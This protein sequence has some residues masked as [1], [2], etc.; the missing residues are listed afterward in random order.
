MRDLLIGVGYFLTT[1]WVTFYGVCL[2]LNPRRFSTFLSRP[3]FARR[4]MEQVQDWTERDGRYWRKQGVV[5]AV[6]GMFMFLMPLVIAVMH[7]DD[8]VSPTTTPEPHHSIASG[9]PSY[10]VWSLFLCLGISLVA[11]PLS[12]LRY[13]RPDKKSITSNSS[14]ASLGPRIVGGVVILI[15][16]FGLF[17]VARH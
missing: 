14:D 7:P 16:L 8:V 3:L 17:Q 4:S 5:M 11:N 13:F 15:A 9:W 10:V 12:V 1:A 6:S 2:L